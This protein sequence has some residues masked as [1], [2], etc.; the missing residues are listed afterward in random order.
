MGFPDMYDIL[1]QGNFG[2]GDW[3]LM[4]SGNYNGGSFLPAGYSSYERM[5]CGWNDPV[6][7]LGDTVVTDIQPSISGGQ[8]FIIYNKGHRDE[9]YLIENRQRQGWDAGL[10]GSGMLVTHVD[11]DSTL[12]AL[13]IV[14]A[15]G[16]FSQYGLKGIK[17][18]HQRLTLVH[19]DD[20]DDSQYFNPNTMLFFI[21]FCLLAND[22][23]GT[24]TPTPGK[25]TFQL[26]VGLS[27]KLFALTKKAYVFFSCSFLFSLMD[28]SFS[29]FKRLLFLFLFRF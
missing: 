7:L 18:D 8:T 11:Y 21:S 19:A 23:L 22:P 25:L 9:Y 10:P 16:D 24:D 6:E 29:V 3:D 17:N 12:W 26:L 4:D 1:Y 27:H 13:N 15:T 2:M 28:I 14:N 5:L 20:D